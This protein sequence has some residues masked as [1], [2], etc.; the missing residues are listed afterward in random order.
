MEHALGSQNRPPPS[1]TACQKIMPHGK[2]GKRAGFRSRQQEKWTHGNRGSPEPGA[3][4][5][6]PTSRS[7][8]S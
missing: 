5:Q 4:V 1:P 8:D 2:V 7:A 3:V 6:P